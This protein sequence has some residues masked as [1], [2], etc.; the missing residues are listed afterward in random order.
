MAGQER[1]NV[2][3]ARGLRELVIDASESE[4]REDLSRANESLDALATHA[5]S[6]VSRALD[7]A[8]TR[9][10]LVNDLHRGLG[11]L[12]QMLRRRD[13]LSAQELA[14]G[15]RVDLAELYAIESDPAV[16]PQPRTIYQ[17]AEYFG[18]PARSLL[19]LSGAFE[20]VAQEV[21]EKAVRFATH[22]KGM[23][24][25]SKEEKRLLNEFV[26][27]LQEQTDR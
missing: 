19:M 3:M 4:L 25:L 5:Q 16:V 11:A 22:S 17:V 12:I 9:V 26:R 18:L 23:S 20:D 14:I 1:D 24:K 21:R 27:F 7:R 2:K 13:K 6:V 10:S 15:A 8:S